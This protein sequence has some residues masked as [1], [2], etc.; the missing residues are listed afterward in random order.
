MPDAR[1]Q[2]YMFY[3][4]YQIPDARNKILD[5]RCQIQ[6]TSHYNII[7]FEPFNIWTYLSITVFDWLYLATNETDSP[8]ELKLRRI[9][10]MYLYI[11]YQL[12]E[13]VALSFDNSK[14]EIGTQGKMWHLW[15]SIQ[16][17]LKSDHPHEL[18]TWVKKKPF[19]VRGRQIVQKYIKQITSG[20]LPKCPM[21]K[22]AFKDLEDLKDHMEIFCTDCKTY[23]KNKYPK[24]DW[25]LPEE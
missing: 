15:I 14:Y 19:K 22:V 24:S 17:Q 9:Y 6:N 8:V 1:S 11:K 18:S 20:K 13:Q 10:K 16:R 21:C 5:T 23:V 3:A 4:R 7:I 25:P 12:H 2:F